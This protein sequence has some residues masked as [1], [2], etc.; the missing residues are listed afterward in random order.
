MTPIRRSSRPPASSATEGAQV[1]GHL[2]FYKVGHHGSTN[3]TPI[4]AVEAMGEDFVSMC[5]TQEDS[6]RLGGEPVRSAA[7]PA[8]GGPRR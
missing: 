5:S 4:A 8:D 1:L 3:A 7:H 6:L 2:D